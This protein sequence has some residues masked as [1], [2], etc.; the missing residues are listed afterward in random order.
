MDLGLGMAGGARQ[1]TPLESEASTP[2]ALSGRVRAE[3]ERALFRRMPA[4]LSASLICAGLVAYNV[5][6]DVPRIPLVAWIALMVAGTCGRFWLWHRGRFKL[7]GVG[8]LSHRD[9]TA[10]VAGAAFGGVLWGAITALVVLSSASAPDVMLVAFV[11]AG[12]GAGAMAGFSVYP[13]MFYAS[14][15]SNLVPATAVL[16]IRAE[17]PYP[18]MGATLLVFAA[19]VLFFGRNLRRG[20][21][22]SV[23]LRFE[24]LD[25][26]R[27][28]ARAR[29]DAEALVE[30]R[31]QAL[32]RANRDLEWRIRETNRTEAALRDTAAQLNLIADNLPVYIS[33]IGPDFR[34]R[35]VNAKYRLSLGL[36]AKD[37]VGRPISE[38]FGA[39]VFEEVKP[40][41]ERALAGH[42]AV[43]EVTRRFS[44][45]ERIL[46][47]VLVPQRGEDGAGNSVV[48]LAVDVTDERL[49][50]HAL[51]ESEERLRRVIQ[52]MPVMMYALDHEGHIIAW[53]RECERV[54]GF[55]AARIVGQ[56]KGFSFLF[57]EAP[58]RDEVRRSIFSHEDFRDWEAGVTCA[59]GTVKT[60]S[61]FNISGSF[62]V[63]GW[64]SWGIGVDV[65][66]RTRARESLE[67][68]L[69]H[70]RE[71]GEL[72]SRFVAMASHEFRTPLTSI[73]AS[74]DL[75]RRY[76]ERMSEE[77]KFENF[78]SINRE[79]A[80][81]TALLEDIL[82][83]G[84]AEAG[85]VGFHP[86][87]IDLQALCLDQLERAK[88]VAKSN[89]EF[90]FDWVGQCEAVFADE[91]L[92]RHILTNML[93]NAIKYSPKGGLIAVNLICG[94][95]DF[96][97]SVSDRGIG[98]PAEGRELLFDAFHRFANVGTISGTGLGF[99][100]MHRAAERHG[101]TISVESVEGVGTTVTALLPSTP[102]EMVSVAAL[103]PK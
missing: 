15:F 40:H 27:G 36:A 38:V 70:E 9:R 76:G 43:Y 100:I 92:V 24:N 30:E 54:T 97:L 55:A 16:F 78:R 88:L 95:R 39:K 83:L 87:A 10:L 32:S 62:P 46:R 3:L 90:K 102:P 50:E 34:Y 73:Q 66:D 48:S 59:D 18:I 37:F 35:F 67:Q 33:L 98:I 4:A 86:A 11:S 72:K 2:T 19:A 80:T 44:E 5:W 81:V 29:E 45:G 60:V 42:P 84:R 26:V 94:E 58:Y 47:V 77:Q 51:R 31:T 1:A 53:N 96:R 17:P 82:T 12:I 69:V 74:V 85:Q 28:L 22:K 63:P 41:L 49:R 14:L 52:N 64:G 13:A 79:I 89:H 57:P 20:M 99:A 65:S 6:A 21:E 7:G 8:S 61:W 68:A 103:Q 56:A 71:L 75:I 23:V 25:L 101:G 93:S 91:Q